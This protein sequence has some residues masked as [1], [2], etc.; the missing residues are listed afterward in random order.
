ML[1]LQSRKERL[2]QNPKPIQWSGPLHYYYCLYF[3]KCQEWPSCLPSNFI[4]HWH[5]VHRMSSWEE[6]GSIERCLCNSTHQLLLLLNSSPLPCFCRVGCHT[7]CKPY[8]S[9]HEPYSRQ[10][11]QVGPGRDRQLF[12]STVRRVHAYQMNWTLWSSVLWFGPGSL[13]WKLPKYIPSK[14]L[15]TFTFEEQQCNFTDYFMSQSLVPFPLSSL[16]FFGLL[17]K[18]PKIAAVVLRL[19]RAWKSL[20]SLKAT[21]NH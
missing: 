14:M 3:E 2:S 17:P 21:S 11:F 7:W 15:C 8:S 20:Q 6:T 5:V 4:T 9:T 16:Q 18:C 1:S 10:P 13:M 19:L 12:P